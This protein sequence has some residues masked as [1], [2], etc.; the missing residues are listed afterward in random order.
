M[1]SLN[2]LIGIDKD[3]TGKT[4]ET[5]SDLLRAK[6]ANSFDLGETAKNPLVR[7]AFEAVGREYEARAA[8]LDK[9]MGRLARDGGRRDLWTVAV[10][11]Q[12]A[13]R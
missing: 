1:P 13:K 9:K 10:S 3:D 12:E 2:V 7:R 6:A 4:V 5:F 8:A 11:S